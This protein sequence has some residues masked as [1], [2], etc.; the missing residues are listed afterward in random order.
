MLRGI[1]GRGLRASSRVGALSHSTLVDEKPPGAIPP[2]PPLPRPNSIRV[3]WG[4]GTQ[5]IISGA[6]C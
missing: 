6:A 5:A 4:T 2:P 3:E 1:A